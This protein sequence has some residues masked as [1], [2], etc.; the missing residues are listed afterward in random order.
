M[1]HHGGGTEELEVGHE[2]RLLL[3]KSPVVGESQIGSHA[4]SIE[5]SNHANMESLGFGDRIGHITPEF[6]RVGLHRVFC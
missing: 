6:L 2:E 1:A 5:P 4:S 3:I